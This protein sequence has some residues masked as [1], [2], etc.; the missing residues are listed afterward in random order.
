MRQAYTH[1]NGERDAPTVEGIYWFKGKIHHRDYAHD[2]AGLK[3]VSEHWRYEGHENWLVE[4]E[5][6]EH[7]LKD[8][9]GQW[10]G[11][12]EAPWQDAQ[13]APAGDDAAG[14]V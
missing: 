10:W 11:P 14:A 6:S 2:A 9:E 5:E 4:S 7:P 8:A 13:P 12:I 1:R 3:S